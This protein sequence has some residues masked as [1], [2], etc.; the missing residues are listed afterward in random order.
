MQ[1][2]G[3][4]AGA[5]VVGTGAVNATAVWQ[6]AKAQR[7]EL[8]N[9]LDRLEDQR[10]SL[11]NDIEEHSLTG[12]AKTG[13]ENRIAE[14]DKRISDVEKQIT[15]SNAAV[16][17]AAGVQGAVVAPPPYQRDGPPEEAFVLG[18]IF[19]VVVMLPL[20]I[21]FARRIWRRG[22]TAVAAFPSDLMDRLSRLDQA[23]DSIAV[24]VERI[25][26]G[27]RF[28]T[29][30]MS[31]NGRALGVGAAQPADAAARERAAISKEGR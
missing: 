30:L 25:G 11:V 6:A 12:V 3:S 8:G 9:Q 31:E 22:A 13:V 16:A 17:T 28:V 2:Q 15:T 14:I 20:S 27:Q 19:I 18:G 5:N 4:G 29:R 23:V 24:E 21:A 10:R 26:E 1:A 7:E